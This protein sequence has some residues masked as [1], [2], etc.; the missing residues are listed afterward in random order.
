MAV[1]AI[2]AETKSLEE[3]TPVQLTVARLYASGK[4]RSSI[5]HRLEQYLLTPNQRKMKPL[6]RRYFAMRRLRRWE[7]KKDFRDLIW[8]LS[9]ERLDMRTPTILDGVAERA[10]AG[11]VD[12]AKLSLEVAGRYSPKGQDQATAVQI[13]VNGVPRPMAVDDSVVIDGEI[14]AEDG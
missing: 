6:R 11:R 7:Q 3:W 5:A 2:T 4:T 8:A 12:A 14:T 1:P 9:V 13:V 10:E